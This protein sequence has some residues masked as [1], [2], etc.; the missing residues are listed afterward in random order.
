METTSVHKKLRCIITNCVSGS[1]NYHIS[2]RYTWNKRLGKHRHTGGI[3]LHGYRWVHNHGIE[4]VTGRNVG[5]NRSKTIYRVCCDREG[6]KGTV[7]E[8]A[9]GVICI[10]VQNTYIL[11]K[12]CDRPE[13]DDFRLNTYGPS[14]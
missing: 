9:E 8:V 10:V 3:I 1:H 14:V 4:I 6:C 7:C 12:T 5:E 13:N 11:P 2:H